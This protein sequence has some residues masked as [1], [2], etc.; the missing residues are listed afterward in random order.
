ML[1]LMSLLGVCGAKKIRPAGRLEAADTGE[2]AEP[3]GWT[4]VSGC[5]ACCMLGTEVAEGPEGG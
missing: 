2:V 3:L 5:G 1:N 4:C